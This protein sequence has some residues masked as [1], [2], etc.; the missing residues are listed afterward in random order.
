ME[1]NFK[2]YISTLKNNLFITQ[3]LNSQ[4]DIIN[5]Q[6][7]LLLESNKLRYKEKN[8]YG[9][10]LK[11]NDKL[12]DE[13][14]FKIKN[15]TEKVEKIK[16][17]ALKIQEKTNSNLEKT[18]KSIS[19]FNKLNQEVDDM[20]GD[21]KKMEE[22]ISQIDINKIL[23]LSKKPE[24]NLLLESNDT[25]QHEKDVLVARYTFINDLI[26][27][28]ILNSK[29]F[30]KYIPENLFD[31]K[32]KDKYTILS[33]ELIEERNKYI[34]TLF[35]MF[36][37]FKNEILKLIDENTYNDIFRLIND[38]KTNNIEVKKSDLQLIMKLDV[39][40]NNLNNNNP[41][42]FDKFKTDNM[43]IINV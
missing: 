11:E 22:V 4:V 18:I 15:L 37:S 6:L 26:N 27:I 42:L 5:K 40:I 16:Q 39:G 31:E 9:G 35:I 29:Y 12:N 10:S 21:D 32:Y 14:D 24:S 41:K 25:K 8:Q 3:N 13:L 19:S 7:Q 23:N 34:E 36:E 17:K 43:E 2:N 38:E 33:K 30:N 1:K 28:F 20:L